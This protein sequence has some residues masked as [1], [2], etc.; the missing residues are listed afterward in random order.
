M[1]VK[2]YTDGTWQFP[3]ARIFALGGAGVWWPGRQ[4]STHK[5]S[6]AETDMAVVNQLSDGVQLATHIGGYAGS[7]TRTELAAG[8]LAIC[9][10]GPVHLASDSESFVNRANEEFL[11]M[12]GLALPTGFAG[13]PHLMGTC[14][15]ISRRLSW[16]KARAL[17]SSHGLRGTPPKT[18]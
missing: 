7:S 17:F 8:I 10:H 12:R 14:G 6:S 4:L 16:P 2:V 11:A 18:T 13:T 5:A 1:Q 9:S 3:L 15:I